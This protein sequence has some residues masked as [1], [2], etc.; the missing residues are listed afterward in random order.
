MSK[1]ST[2]HSALGSEVDI[3]PV[4]RCE[5]PNGVSFVWN[6]FDGFP[7]EFSECGAVYSEPPWKKG[8]EEF[9]RRA[10]VDSEELTYQSLVD[11]ISVACLNSG[12]P[13]FILVSKT[14]VNKY[15]HYAGVVKV[16]FEVHN[17]CEC[18][19][20]CYNVEAPNFGGVPVPT[21]LL[22]KW[23]VKRY[24]YVADFCCGYGNTGE[25][26]LENGGRVVLCDYNP[27]CIAVV[28]SRFDGK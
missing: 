14:D 8:F 13:C 3:E 11:A 16:E 15:K 28:K 18:L 26:V 12:K 4:Q 10:G 1:W 23:I 2:Y 7:K 24:E 22:I 17:S 27:K 6:I 20:L 21:S 5:F 19:C 9:N 25:K